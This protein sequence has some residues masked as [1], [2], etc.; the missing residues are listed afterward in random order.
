M[1]EMERVERD[2]NGFGRRLN[3]LE[4]DHAGC[5]AETKS[6]IKT[7]KTWTQDQ[8]AKLDQLQK[9]HADM[10]VTVATMKD[11]II[12]KVSGRMGL[13]VGAM[14]LILGVLMFIK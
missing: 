14:T 10:K 1:N 2:L 6:E 7:L 8:E 5:S 9:D 11:E 12:G 4:T 13:M 3:K